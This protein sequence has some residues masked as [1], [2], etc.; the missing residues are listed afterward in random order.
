MNCIKRV[1]IPVIVCGNGTWHSVEVG[2]RLLGYVTNPTEDINHALA[3]QR[4]Q[5]PDGLAHLVWVEAYVPM[6]AEPDSVV[7]FSTVEGGAK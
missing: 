5:D 1:R 3:T 6:P 7:G 4:E 2:D